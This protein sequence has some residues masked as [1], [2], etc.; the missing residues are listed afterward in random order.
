M[1]PPPPPRRPNTPETAHGERCWPK[2]SRRRPQAQARIVKG[3]GRWN[4]RSRRARKTRRVQ[5]RE[6]TC[7]Q[8]QECSCSKRTSLRAQHCL[9]YCGQR[10]P[11]VRVRTATSA[12]HADSSV[13]PQ[14]LPVRQVE[15]SIFSERDS[16]SG[17]RNEAFKCSNATNHGSDG[18]DP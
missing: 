18:W 6:T 10:G 4:L 5:L 13:R 9:V 7:R 11:C 8:R 12:T 16:Q 17:T 1:Q 15:V 3:S 14:L 2:A